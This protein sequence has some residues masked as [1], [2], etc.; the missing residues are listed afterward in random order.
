SGF[1]AEA[2]LLAGAAFQQLLSGLISSLTLV[3]ELAADHVLAL[4]LTLGFVGRTGDVD[5]DRGRDLGVQA[6]QHLVDA[7]RLD[8]RVQDDLRALDLAAFG[9]DGLSDVATGDRT[10]QLAGFA[11]LTDHNVALT[12]DLVGDLLSVGL[13]L[14][15]ALLD[16]DA[17]DFEGLQV[18]FG[19]ATSLVARQKGVTGEAG[20]D[21]DGVADGAEVRA[22]LQQNGLHLTSPRTARTPLRR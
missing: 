22:A 10:V 14:L 8:R 9:A 11:S 17:L 12:V 4:R 1:V 20:L 19:G 5:L 6:D 16:G 7:Q 13:V 15:V 21:G 3:V 2:F 18:G